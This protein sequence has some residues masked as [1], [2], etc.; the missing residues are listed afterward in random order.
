MEPYRLYRLAYNAADPS[1]RGRVVVFIR[2]HQD[3]WDI[4]RAVVRLIDGGAEYLV[5]PHIVI[6]F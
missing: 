5:T 4:R 3:P 2:Y 1:L 6:P